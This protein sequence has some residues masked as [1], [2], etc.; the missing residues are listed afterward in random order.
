MLHFPSEHLLVF[1]NSL[2]MVK[3]SDIRNFLLEM[4]FFRDKILKVLRVF[5]IWLLGHFFSYK[6]DAKRFYSLN[7]TIIGERK[8]VKNAL[9][10][11][12]DDAIMFRI[13]TLVYD[14]LPFSNA[15]LVGIIYGNMQNGYLFF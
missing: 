12:F 15:T 13:F 7:L 9:F 4:L 2:N 5:R 8:L 3:Y 1:K 10:H 6:I 11:V 14:N